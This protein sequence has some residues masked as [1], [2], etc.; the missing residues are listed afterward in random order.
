MVLI[1][2]DDTVMMTKMI[3]MQTIRR[4]KMMIMKILQLLY[5]VLSDVKSNMAAGAVPYG[6]VC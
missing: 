5:R 4:I 6:M 3:V 1:S 2:D